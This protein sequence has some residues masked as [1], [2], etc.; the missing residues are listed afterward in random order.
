MLQ[1]KQKA[2]SVAPAASA[3]SENFINLASQPSSAASLASAASAVDPTPPLETFTHS[4]VISSF[5]G[6]LLFLTMFS[7]M[8]M[9]VIDPDTSNPLFEF[10]L[11]FLIVLVL[12]SFSFSYIMYC[13]N[14]I[15]IDGTYMVGNDSMKQCEQNNYILDTGEYKVSAGIG[16]L[17]GTNT[18]NE[19][20][21]IAN[22]VSTFS[23]L[24][25]ILGYVYILISG[26]RSV[27][28][29]NS[30][31]D[32]QFGKRGINGVDNIDQLLLE[33]ETSDHQQIKIALM[34]IY[35]LFTIF[36]SEV[37]SI[38]DS[39]KTVKYKLKIDTTIYS[40]LYITNL[41]VAFLI[42]ALPLSQMRN[43]E[44]GFFSKLTTLLSSYFSNI[45]TLFRNINKA[46]FF[47]LIIIIVLNRILNR[48]ITN[49]NSQL[50]TKITN[51]WYL[52]YIQP[53]DNTAANGASSTPATSP[54]LMTT[55]DNAPFLKNKTLT[56]L[57]NYFIEYFK[58]NIVN[59]FANSPTPKFASDPLLVQNYADNLYKFIQFDRGTEMNSVVNRLQNYIDTNN[60]K[61]D[62]SSY[63]TIY[64]KFRLKSAEKGTVDID[65]DTDLCYYI[66]LINN[67]RTICFNMK[68]DKTLKDFIRNKMKYLILISLFLVFFSIYLLIH[69]IIKD[70]TINVLNYLIFV[71]IVL[72]VVMA[73]YGWTTGFI[74]S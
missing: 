42:L 27:I 64:E 68:T 60:Y 28:K 5:I 22:K 49:L 3:A 52:K 62:N 39:L 10:M 19:T 53:Y 2:A 29:G 12:A 51:D 18:T 25:M 23:I 61:I 69:P 44:G 32:Q 58:Q 6:I 34:I 38:F 1:A 9:M 55:L 21:N 71:I 48:A 30:P 56:E 16:G 33:D 72:A 74:Y 31:H 36:G 35:V 63:K 54:Y 40:K 14:L 8:Y 26:Y 37:L 70:N 4:I 47:I 59:A 50:F 17:G 11:T 43:T 67:I 57:D 45:I 13:N 20:L 66:Q 41:G 15:N 73:G 65:T 24:I 7:M 46:H